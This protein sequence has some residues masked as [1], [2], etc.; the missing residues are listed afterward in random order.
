MWQLKNNQPPF[1]MV[2]GPMAGSVFKHGRLYG[3]VPA[4]HE[5]RF[6]QTDEVP[7]ASPTGDSDDSGPTVIWAEK[8]KDEKEVADA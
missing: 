1:E 3:E 5:H 7:V 6:E 4:G 2:D 8:K